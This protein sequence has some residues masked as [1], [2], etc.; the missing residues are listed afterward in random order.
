M[1]SA[2]IVFYVICF[3]LGVI[4]QKNNL[5]LSSS[6]HEEARFIS[7]K[8]GDSVTLHCYYEQKVAAIFYWYKQ[9]LGEKPKLIS[10]FFESTNNF[11][12]FHDPFNNTTHFRLD[13]GKGNNHLIIS[14]L[15]VS[16]SA[17]YYCI[18][19]YLY[20]LMF[21]ET[22]IVSV[23]DSDLNIRTLVHQS[24]SETIQPGGSVSLHCMVHTMLSC[25]GEH[26]VYWFKD[27]EDSQPGLIYTHGVRN[28]QCE[29]K[30]NKSTHTCVYNLRM[31]SLNVSHTGIYY[32]AV[33][34]CG[35]ILFGNGTKLDFG[36]F[37]VRRD[38]AALMYFLSAALTLTTII[39][40]LSTFLVYKMKRSNNCQFKDSNTNDSVNLESTQEDNLHYAALRKIR[41]KGARR[42]TSN[43]QDTCLY[44]E[45]VY[46]GIK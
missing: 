40:V 6:V 35:H 34:S 41:T 12:H 1:A 11:V 9:T 14:D 43:T 16:D 37:T 29:R 2:H 19:S 23:N 38:S 44:S 26:S 10:T 4:A 18:R 24:A 7:A 36:G 45:Y 31:E 30:D 21:L 20:T 5:H 33:A 22:I 39:S 27:S 32:C 8:S 42:Q 13:N 46:S 17:T 15:S 28:D 25:D 3:F